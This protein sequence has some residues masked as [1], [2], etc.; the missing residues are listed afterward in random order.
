MGAQ[1]LGIFTRKMVEIISSTPSKMY[2]R[3]GLQ[4]ELYTESVSL[5]Q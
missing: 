1:R 4:S 5:A 2:H 3:A